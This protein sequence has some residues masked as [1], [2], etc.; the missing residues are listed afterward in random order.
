LAVTGELLDELCC[1]TFDCA[2]V[3]IDAI[4]EIDAA[5]RIV[6]RK[7]EADATKSGARAAS[8]ECLFER[9]P[10]RSVVCL[11]KFTAMRIDRNLCELPV[12][13]DRLPRDP[14]CMVA[15]AC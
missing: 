7:H 8:L 11:G 10:S 4:I 2:G 12:A 3:R 6:G 9:A 14:L 13:L 5:I 15:Q 1:P